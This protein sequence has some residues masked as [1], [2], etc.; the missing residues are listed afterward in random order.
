MLISICMCTYKRKH[1]K[2]TLVSIV[3]LS[4]KPEM[5]IEVV[6]VDND[7]AMSGKPTFESV[8]QNF[9]HTLIYASETKKNISAAR[10]KCLEIAQGEWIAFID[11]DEVADSEWL[12]NLFLAVKTYDADVVFGRVATIYPATCPHWI[13]AGKY[14]DRKIRQTGGIVS[15][16]ACN[17]TLVNN[18]LRKENNLF[19]DLD[20]GLSGGEDADFF[21][22]LHNFG[23]KLVNSHEA[24]VEEEVEPQRLN[25]EYLVKRTLRVGQTFTKYRY[26][27]FHLSLD[28]FKF[29]CKTCLQLV[30][31]ALATLV[32]LPLGKYHYFKYY[33][34]MVDKYGKLSFF[35]N[36]K[37]KTLYS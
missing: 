36:S 20:Y 1:L 9:P 22:R 35:V 29:V 25:T 31:L 37:S 15:S 11:D 14:F 27:R 28:V 17:S 26:K 24:F 33:L 5:E 13:I 10:N 32:C 18:K 30:A 3:N 6:V 16:G 19:F 4:L 34:K 7:E 23:A 2:D 8:K 21:H 12:I